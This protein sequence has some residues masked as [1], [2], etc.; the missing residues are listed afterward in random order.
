MTTT[1]TPLFTKS[2]TQYSDYR[3]YL[4]NVLEEKQQKNS[5]YSLRSFAKT[6]GVAPSSLSSALSGT[7]GLSTQHAQIVGKKLGLGVLER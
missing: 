3:E 1:P 7:R 6:I 4:R 5:R 2:I